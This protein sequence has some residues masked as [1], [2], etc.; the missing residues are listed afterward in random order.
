MEV[1]RG[2]LKIY[3]SLLCFTGLWPYNNSVVIKI[4]R[5]AI[6]LILCGCIANQ[7]STIGN[8]KITLNE[9]ITQISF[10]CT[11]FLYISRYFTTIITFPSIRYVFDSMEEDY[12]ALKNSIELELLMKDLVTAKHIIQAY[13]VMTCA[14]IVCLFISLGLPTFFETDIQLRLLRLLGFFYTD[15]SS[16]SDL[17]CWSIIV[18]VS[19]GLLTV[20][21]TEGTI[22]VCATY[23]SGLLEIATYRMRTAVNKVANSD[24]INVIDLRPVVEIHLRAIQH[25][26]KYTDDVMLTSLMIMIVV[27]VAFGVHIY[28]L[29]IYITE[30]GEYDEILIT[31][32]FVLAYLAFIC[33][34]NYSGQILLDNSIKLYQETYN[35]LWYRIPPKMQKMVLIAL[36]KSQTAVEFNLAGLFTPCY[37]GFTMMMSSSF[38][39]FTL[40]CSVQ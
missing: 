32:Y 24:T 4:Y 7:L 36:I 10:G 29:Y 18:A 9:I 11:L 33:G 20:S 19:Y 13:F 5:L 31:S 30:E 25:S 26:K 14:G 6:M 28:R 23:F 22:S 8:T 17:S 40:L 15:R 35:S 3:Y 27:V 21:C 34:N 39:Y 37:E 38:S 16:Q 1:F 2:N 12:V